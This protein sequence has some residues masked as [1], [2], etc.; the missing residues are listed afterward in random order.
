VRVIFGRY[1]SAEIVDFLLDTIAMMEP[2]LSK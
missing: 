2:L 1:T